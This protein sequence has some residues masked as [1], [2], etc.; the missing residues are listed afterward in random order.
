MIIPNG[1]VLRPY[2]PRRLLFAGDPAFNGTL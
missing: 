1:S 2:G